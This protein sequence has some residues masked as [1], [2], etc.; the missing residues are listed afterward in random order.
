MRGSGQIP[1]T[2]LTF[3][4]QNPLSV[5]S[6]PALIKMDPAGNV[7]WGTHAGTYVSPNTNAATALNGQEV[8]F[9]GSES[10]I[11][12][13]TVTFPFVP[14]RGYNA[15]LA[16]FN[17][18]DGSFIAMDSLSSNWGASERVSALG[19]DPRGN[20]Y[21]GGEFESRLFVA[22]Y[23]KNPC[24]CTLPHSKFSHT[25]SAGGTVTFTYTGG[26]PFDR[27]EWSYGNGLEETLTATTA[28][29][30]YTD[31][32]EYRVCLTVYDDSCGYDTWCMWLDPFLLETPE[33]LVRD[34]FT[35]Y[36]NPAQTGF[37]L[38]CS[39]SLSYMLFDLSGRWLQGGTAAVGSTWISLENA[40]NG[41]YLLQVT[42]SNGQTETVKIVK[43]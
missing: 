9:A 27:L 33:P 34:L 32:G 2:F 36:P 21:V 39:E 25:V 14:N 40:Q 13:G 20:V 42:N 16:R 17:K 15:Y 19:A 5:R 41:I 30:T 3:T 23:G 43:N 4:A 7:V 29:H 35:Y 18:A 11:S 1:V 31:A 24:N 22:K 6:F 28:T 37:T 12:W 38:A 10:G 8:I 26:S